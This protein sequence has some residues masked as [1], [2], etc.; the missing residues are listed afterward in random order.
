MTHYVLG[1]L[2]SPDMSQVVLV[3]KNRP[4]WQ[5]GKIN[6]IGGHV[7]E[8]EDFHTAMVREFREETGL[9]ISSWYQ[10]G[11]LVCSDAT[12]GLF[13][14]LADTYDKVK[15]TTDELIFISPVCEVIDSWHIH[16]LLPNLRWMI[17]MALSILQGENARAFTITEMY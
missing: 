7:E 5:A 15:S 13:F 4:Q 9:E 12:V 11:T 3:Q 6:G 2:F 17:P 14:A 16:N 8:G 10:F 1:F